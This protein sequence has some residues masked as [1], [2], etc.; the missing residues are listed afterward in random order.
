[1]DGL[2]H[3]RTFYRLKNVNRMTSV[4][5][6]KESVAEHTWSSLV[7]ADFFLE[8]LEDGMIIANG[9]RVAID[10]LKVFEILLYHDVVEIEAGDTPLHPHSKAIRPDEKLALRRLKEDL[11]KHMREKVL[12]LFH[13]FEDTTSVEGRFARAIDALDAIIQEL[14]YPDDWKGWS[15][16]FL[17]KN[18]ERR[19]REFPDCAD[20]FEQLL[21]FQRDRGYFAKE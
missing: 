14:D 15:E 10:K 9:E 5:G 21:A 11:P 7:L 18:K 17:R 12:S 2:D 3:L 13:E 20:F 16:E 4:Q 1:M 8:K 6:R 19:V